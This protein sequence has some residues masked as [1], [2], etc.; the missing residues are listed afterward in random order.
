M[1]DEFAGAVL[2]WSAPNLGLRA[3]GPR[4]LRRVVACS[5]E[6]RLQ[7]RLARALAAGVAEYHYTAMPAGLS[8]S[9]KLHCLR[10]TKTG[11][12]KY[13]Q[14][15]RQDRRNAYA[16]RGGRTHHRPSARKLS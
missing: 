11:S 13:A 4:S 16:P 1:I 7:R 15:L 10:S 5:P 12:T 8:L 3:A 6:R 14:G 2:L 9:P